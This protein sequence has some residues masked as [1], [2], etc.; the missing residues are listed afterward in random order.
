[1]MVMTMMIMMM[2]TIIGKNN[3]KC[4]SVWATVRG[5]FI[6]SN[7]KFYVLASLSTSLQFI[8]EHIFLY[9]PFTVFFRLKYSACLQSLLLANI[10]AKGVWYAQFIFGNNK[11]FGF[12]YLDTCETHLLIGLAAS[13][14]WSLKPHSQT[15]IINSTKMM[16]MTTGW[17]FVWGSWISVLNQGAI[18]ENPAGPTPTWTSRINTLS[19]SS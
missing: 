18:A 6:V 15:S 7:S 13:P 4:V 9:A 1:M 12:P 3:P 8:Q 11:N 10:W 17:V 16:I 19:A 5:I 2:I 14:I